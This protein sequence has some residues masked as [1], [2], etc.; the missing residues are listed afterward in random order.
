[1]LGVKQR[2]WEVRE[3][4]LPRISSHQGLNPMGHLQKGITGKWCALSQR[5]EFIFWL[6]HRLAMR[7]L[8]SDLPSLGLDFVVCQEWICLSLNVILKFQ[9]DT[10]WNL[11]PTH[12]RLNKRWR[13]GGRGKA[14]LQ[15]LPSLESV[16]AGRQNF[17][18]VI[19]IS[20]LL[21]FAN[22]REHLWSRIQLASFVY[23]HHITPLSST[24]WVFNARFTCGTAEAQGTQGYI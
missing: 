9:W 1:M 10:V 6:G 17:Q 22:L 24:S 7:P 16:P 15:H 21:E 4:S 19:A 2:N 3:F 12:S 11:A 23:F 14:G 13:G 20:M 18:F 5:L 8:A